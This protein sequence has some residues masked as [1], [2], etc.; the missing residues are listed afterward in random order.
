MS[1]FLADRIRVAGF[2]FLKKKVFLNMR[3]IRA[4]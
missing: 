2:Y 1:P 4:K 3:I